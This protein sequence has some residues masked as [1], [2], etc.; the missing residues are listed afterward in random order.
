LRYVKFQLYIHFFCSLYETLL[1]ESIYRLQKTEISMNR[2]NEKIDIPRPAATVILTRE[3]AG[4]LQV[5]LLKRSTKSGFMA[6]NYVFPGGVLESGDGAKNHWQEHIDLIPAE[7]SERLGGSLREQDILPYGIA[8]IRET[9]EEAGVFLGHNEDQTKAGLEE[10][11]RMRREAGLS[12]GWLLDLIET[13]KWTLAFSQLYRWSHWITPPK[14]KKRF[15]TRFFISSM[16]ADQECRPDNR[17]TTHGIW[18]SPQT[19]LAGNLSGD[20]PLSPPTLATLHELLSYQR[21]SDLMQQAVQKSWGDALMP[22]LA[23]ADKDP[24]I[25]EPWDP[26]YPKEKIHLNVAELNENL[27]GV[28]EPFSRLWHHEGIWRPVKTQT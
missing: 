19:G 21:L 17:E 6:G 14:M 15:N 3:R 10:L 20:I 5:Y 18:V 26:M 1:R 7:L 24:V 8:A 28:G 4:E 16:P 13:R 9:F 11:D 23:F 25:V 22:R 2:K 27:V 12:D